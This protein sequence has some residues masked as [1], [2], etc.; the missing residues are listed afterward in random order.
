MSKVVRGL[1]LGLALAGFL[2]FLSFNI[3]RVG[4]KITVTVGANPWPWLRYSQVR[5]MGALTENLKFDVLS[6]SST[7]LVAGLVFLFLRSKVK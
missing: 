7:G 6:W 4:P 3:D 1:L 2:F 5:L